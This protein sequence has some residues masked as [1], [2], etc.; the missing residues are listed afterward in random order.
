MAYN[1]SV[2]TCSPALRSVIHHV[3]LSEI[4]RTY[5]KRAQLARF[6]NEQGYELSGMCAAKFNFSVSNV[7]YPA[8]SD[9][10]GAKV[11]IDPVPLPDQCGT[12][13]YLVP[14]HCLT[15]MFPSG[16]G[17]LCTLLKM[18]AQR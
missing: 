4:E 6:L 18:E 16:D 11:A 14:A 12:K 8:L 15:P 2:L 5:I 3:V 1:T 7:V 9:R 13:K 17:M 10:V